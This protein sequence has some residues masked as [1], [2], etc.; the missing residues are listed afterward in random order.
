MT[1]L[2]FLQRRLDEDEQDI[3]TLVYDGRD[4]PPVANPFRLLSGLEANRL[5]VEAAESAL[6]DG[7]IYPDAASHHEETLKRLARAYADHPDYQAKWRP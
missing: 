7:G 5:I 3:K 2:E 4:Y 6:D 1:L